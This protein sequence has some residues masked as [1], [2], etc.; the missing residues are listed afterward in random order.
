MY[1]MLHTRSLHV[2]PIYKCLNK[3]I[4]RAIATDVLVRIHSVAR[5]WVGEQNYQSVLFKST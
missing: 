3:L 1:I 5:R 2:L 4:T